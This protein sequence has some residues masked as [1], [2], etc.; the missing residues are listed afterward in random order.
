MAV[1]FFVQDRDLKAI[2]S[3]WKTNEHFAEFVSEFELADV[4]YA[5]EDIADKYFT[6]ADAI[7]T[8]HF[9]QWRNDYLHIALAGDN[10][11]AR[12]IANWLLELP[13]PDDMSLEY[14]SKKHKTTINTSVCGQFLISNNTNSKYTCKEFFRI[15]RQ[16]VQEIAEGR[17]LWGD[18]V[19]EKMIK[20]R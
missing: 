15:H 17:K 11:P 14:Y 16:A 4:E 1:H 7:H 5:M 10:V 12:S 18:T 6:R 19:S 2:K 13:I 3:N 20:F 8:K 9:S